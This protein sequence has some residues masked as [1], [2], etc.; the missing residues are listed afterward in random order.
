MINR[1]SEESIFYRREDRSPPIDV[2]FEVRTVRDCRTVRQAG[3]RILECQLTRFDLDAAP[4][5]VRQEFPD[6]TKHP[7]RKHEG[8]LR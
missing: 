2:R 6:T 7:Q 5:R 3:V 8:N 4:T 1:N